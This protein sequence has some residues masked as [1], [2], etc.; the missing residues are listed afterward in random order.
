MQTEMVHRSML[1]TAYLGNS[2]FALKLICGDCGKPYGRKS[3][4]QQAN[5]QRI[6]TDATQK[7]ALEK[8]VKEKAYK[9]GKATKMRAYLEAMKQADDYLEECSE[10]V[11]VLMIET[12]TV[13]KDKNIA[14]K[15]MNGK[16]ITI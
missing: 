11:W 3:D 10:E 7:A 4:I 5:T 2:L 6:S 12:A 14:F 13:Y 15:F 16:E 8:A 1:G 9:T